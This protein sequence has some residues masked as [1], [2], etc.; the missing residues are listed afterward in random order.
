MLQNSSGPFS[1]KTPRSTN[2]SK[3]SLP[4]R[5]QLDNITDPIV[6]EQ[7]M[8]NDNLSN[9]YTSTS[10]GFRNVSYDLD[11]RTY[12]DLAEHAD[13]H[14]INN[15]FGSDPEGQKKLL[16]HQELMFNGIL[17]G[18]SFLESHKYALRVGPKPVNTGT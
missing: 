1:R 10:S 12:K 7:D 17:A 18:M 6:S 15:T 3:F 16:E 4:P 14:I 8:K 2:P 11:W 5:T 13:N 9:L